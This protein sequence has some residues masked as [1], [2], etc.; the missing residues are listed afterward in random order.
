MI[1]TGEQAPDFELPDHPALP[2]LFDDADVRAPVN[3]AARPD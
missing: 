2:H 1:T 3:E